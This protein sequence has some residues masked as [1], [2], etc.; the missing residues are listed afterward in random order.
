MQLA[1]IKI[2]DT[3]F[4]NFGGPLPPMPLKVTGVTED[5][6]LCKGGFEFDRKTGAEIDEELGWNVIAMCTGSFITTSQNTPAAEKTT[7]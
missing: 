7:P 1:D 4:R 6:I 5:R 2:G 3:V